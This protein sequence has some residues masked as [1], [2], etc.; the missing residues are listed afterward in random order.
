M[1]PAVC[2][3][4]RSRYDDT[5]RQARE[6]TSDDAGTEGRSSFCDCRRVFRYREESQEPMILLT[7]ISVRMRSG[8]SHR[9]TSLPFCKGD[10]VGLDVRSCARAPDFMRSGR[11]AARPGR[12]TRPGRGKTLFK[13]AGWQQH[14]IWLGPLGQLLRRDER[15]MPALASSFQG[16]CFT[17]LTC[18]LFLDLCG[19][20]AVRLVPTATP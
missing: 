16:A 4:L 9:I 12:Y 11:T 1:D 8:S 20:R 14:T 17:I 18:S 6:S 7:S 2:W 19:G 13:Q 10:G 15:P 5:F 3:K